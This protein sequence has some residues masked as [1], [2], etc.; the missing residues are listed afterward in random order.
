M[1]YN[2]SDIGH[3]QARIY[4]MAHRPDTGY[5]V[6]KFQ[7]AMIIPGQRCNLLTAA[8]PAATS[9]WA[10][11]A[12]RPDRSVCEAGDSLVMPARD[13]PGLWKSGSGMGEYGARA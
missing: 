1:L 13:N 10:S 8:I 4:R 7:M 5:R 9:Q 2:I 12:T 6:I 11:R 3:R